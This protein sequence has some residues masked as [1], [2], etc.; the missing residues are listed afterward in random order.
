[1][2]DKKIPFEDDI[3]YISQRDRALHM[4]YGSQVGSIK[5]YSK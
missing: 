5:Y 1:M 4:I 3:I 2:G